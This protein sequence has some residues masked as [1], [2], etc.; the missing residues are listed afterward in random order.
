MLCFHW[1]PNR[2]YQAMHTTGAV[3]IYITWFKNTTGKV[4]QW[5]DTTLCDKVCQWLD[6]TLC[7]KVC[8]WLDT[9]LCDKVCQ[10]LDTTI[11]FGYSYS[12][13]AT[14][15]QLRISRTLT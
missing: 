14:N 12:Y 1:M 7:D 11:T 3:D 6:T 9:T 15:V 8:Q 10:W 13:I 2:V 4:C 5:L